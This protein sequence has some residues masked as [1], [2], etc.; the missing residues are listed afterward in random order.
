[1]AL[2]ED[3][4]RVTKA[5]AIVDEAIHKAL[6]EMEED[7]KMLMVGDWVLMSTVTDEDG[8]TTLSR[9]SS[10]TCLAHARVGLLH[11]GLYGFETT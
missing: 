1:M 9:L 4:G 11:E 5:R 6:G 7:G 8:E 2:S 10:E 3:E